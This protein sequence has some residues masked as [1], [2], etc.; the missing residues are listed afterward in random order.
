[1]DYK[2]KYYKYKQKYLN[3][4]KQVGGQIHDDNRIRIDEIYDEKLCFKTFTKEKEG[5]NS[6]VQIKDNYVLRKSNSSEKDM[7]EMY[8]K[9]AI[10]KINPHV[11][12]LHIE[13][14]CNNPDELP[15]KY[16]QVLESYEGDLLDYKTNSNPEYESYKKFIKVQLLIGLFS[17]LNNNMCLG[18][19]KMENIF[20][21]KRKASET[22]YKINYKIGT[23]YYTLST[24]IFVVNA[25]YF[26]CPDLVYDENKKLSEVPYILRMIERIC[27]IVEEGTINGAREI[28]FKNISNVIMTED[29]FV[30]DSTKTVKQTKLILKLAIVKLLTDLIKESGGE[31]HGSKAPEGEIWEIEK[32]E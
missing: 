32:I 24:P 3:L 12:I 9:F 7:Y 5:S 15:Y 19:R 22:P 10:K 16:H 13:K 4:V 28:S 14:E 8:Q 6:L 2:L 1:M 11:I 21:K 31:E 17:L 27:D 18:D 26:K 29:N 25:D 30:N 23:K 20:Y